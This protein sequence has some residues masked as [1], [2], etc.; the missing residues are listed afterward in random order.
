MDDIFEKEERIITEAEKVLVSKGFTSTTEELYRKLLD[1]YKKLLKQVRSV[2]KMSDMMQGKLNSMASELEKLSNIDELTNLYNRRFFNDEY[3]KEWNNALR[4]QSSLGMLIID[5]DY[6]KKYNDTY[7]HL[8]GDRCLQEIANT[9]KRVVKR[10]RDFVARF[11]GEEFVVL[12]PDTDS[13]GCV[14][15]AEKVLASIRALNI[16]NSLEISSDKVSVSIGLG[17]V[18]PNVDMELETLLQ[19]ADKALYCAKKDGRDCFR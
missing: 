1:E 2:V 7:G 8:Q 14:W 12:L 4:S 9:I 16:S 19:I 10:P 15:I 6:F 3:Q 5:I 11:G 13:N 17:V 18:I